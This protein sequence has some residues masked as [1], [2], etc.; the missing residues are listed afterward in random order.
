[1]KVAV[2]GGCC[3]VVVAWSLRY[4]LW[5]IRNKGCW[6]VAHF[7]RSC[8]TFR[9]VQWAFVWSE[10]EALLCKE[11]FSR[12]TG[13][14]SPLQN[15]EDSPFISF[16]FETCYQC[17]G[18]QVPGNLIQGLILPA[19]RCIQKW[20]TTISHASPLVPS[21]PAPLTILF[22]CGTPKAPT[23]TAQLCTATSSAM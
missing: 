14:L 12:R 18:C 16:C 8:S 21:L 20:R 4:S 1:M 3:V 9:E 15:R 5:T 23:F 6:H 10:Y 2:Q 17:L 7:L 13:W 22:V 19:L 11:V